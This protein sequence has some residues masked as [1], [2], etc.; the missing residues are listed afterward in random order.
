M[1]DLPPLFK[2]LPDLA[3][4]KIHGV[5]ASSDPVPIPEAILLETATHYIISIHTNAAGVND[6][7]G[8]KS[9]RRGILKATLEA[10]YPDIVEAWNTKK[11]KEKEEALR[12]ERNMTGYAHYFQSEEK[13][14]RDKDPGVACDQ[15]L[16][17]GMKKHWGELRSCETHWKGGPDFQ[18]CKGCRVSHHMQS[19]EDFDRGIIMT[20]GARVPVCE[21]CAA[22]AMEE[23]GVGHRG[24][25]CDR[26]WTCFPCREGQLKKLAKARRNGHIEGRCVQC[27]KYKTMAEDVEVCLSCSE[28]RTY[29]KYT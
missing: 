26:Q 16:L 25:V 20:R 2:L 12:I 1:S 14:L 9:Q 10:A 6:F 13:E 5:A 15:S 7:V 3:A 28:T 23:Y 11:E 21:D 4:Y 18:V 27:R 24:C 29:E 19:D 17:P 22:K 8:T